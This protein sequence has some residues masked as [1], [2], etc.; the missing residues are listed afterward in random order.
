MR[1]RRF[2]QSGEQSTQTLGQW[3]ERS[4]S[5]VGF[6]RRHIDGERYELACECELHH[7]GD[8]VAGLVLRF[9][10]ARTEVWCDHHLIEGEERAV[11]ARLDV[12][13]VESGAGDLT[14][15]HRFGERF[16]VDDSAARHVDHTEIG[17]GLGE[18]VAADDA[19]GLLGL[20]EV[21]RDEI[22]LR[23]EVVELNHLH[24][25][26]TS[27]IG[28]DVGVVRDET[29]TEAS[30]ALRHQFADATEADDAEG[31]VGEFDTLPTTAL[32]TTGLQR[33]VRLRHVARRRQQ[34]RHG[35]FGGRHD[36]A[37]RRVHHHHTATGG[38]FDIDVVETDA[39]TT[40]HH[41]IGGSGQHLGGDL[42]GRADDEGMD[43]HQG[44][45]QCLRR[46]IET[47]DHVVAGR[48]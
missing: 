7:V 44:V 5:L 9:A 3:E 41:Q 11:G 12:E 15:T 8:G 35:V 47:H 4:K 26:L 20:G 16:F 38:G 39:G 30:R 6:R 21:N 23:D 17:L 37:L 48:P 32:P 29:H 24:T 14:R 10:R 43:P 46:E 33:G 18:D 13:H 40:H 42:R 34:Q 2:A 31:L 25:H 27:A 1:R 45:G 22:A 28:R 36:V 19:L